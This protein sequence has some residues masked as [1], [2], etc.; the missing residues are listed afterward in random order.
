MQL[1]AAGP[2]GI[3]EILRLH[4]EDQL[5]R[6][7]FAKGPKYSSMDAGV[8]IDYIRGDQIVGLRLSQG[9][10][11]ADAHFIVESELELPELRNIWDDALVSMGKDLL[12][13]LATFA[14][15]RKKVETQLRN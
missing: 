8:L 11:G 2:E 5:S 1:E 9:A 6:N 15:D 7:G 10:E 13:K 14:Q 3:L 4:M 12:Q